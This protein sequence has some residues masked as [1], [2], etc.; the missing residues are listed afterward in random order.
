MNFYIIYQNWTIQKLVIGSALVKL[1]YLLPRKEHL[2]P[3]NIEVESTSL[4]EEM[5]YKICVWKPL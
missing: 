3:I 1:K 5:V 4:P 2:A